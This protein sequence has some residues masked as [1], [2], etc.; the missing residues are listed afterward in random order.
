MAGCHYC[1]TR[2]WILSNSIQH[3]SPPLIHPD[4]SC[5]YLNLVLEY[6]SFLHHYSVQFHH[7][8]NF[9]NKT[10]FGR[11]SFRTRVL[12]SNLA[13]RQCKIATAYGL[14]VKWRWWRPEPSFIQSRYHLQ[15]T[16]I[17]CSTETQQW[18]PADGTNHKPQSCIVCIGY[19]FFFALKSDLIF[20]MPLVHSNS[21]RP[22]VFTKLWSSP[23]GRA[24]R[25]SAEIYHVRTLREFKIIR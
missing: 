22:C 14:N 20:C 12:I 5:H 15:F 16:V 6:S 25:F 7:N 2:W 8:N 10:Q 21:S 24:R 17:S 4:K 23:C 19:F 3:I 13:W 11:C 1:F 9:D 18:S